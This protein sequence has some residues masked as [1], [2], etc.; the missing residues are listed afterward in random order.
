M[1]MLEISQGVGRENTIDSVAHTIGGGGADLA[2]QTKKTCGGG[3]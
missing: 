1:K 3:W 2:T